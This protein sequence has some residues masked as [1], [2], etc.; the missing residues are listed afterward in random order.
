MPKQ[1]KLTRAE[2]EAREEL[3]KDRLAIC[4]MVLK[5]RYGND[6]EPWFGEACWDAEGGLGDIL[7]QSKEYPQAIAVVDLFITRSER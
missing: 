5:Q 7:R 1:E 6:W 4:L 2:H 3:L